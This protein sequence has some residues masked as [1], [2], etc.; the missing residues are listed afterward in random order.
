LR[1][2]SIFLVILIVISSITLV[3]SYTLHQIR[4]PVYIH[5]TL[6]EIERGDTGKTIAETL[7]K[8]NVISNKWLFH[9]VI[10]WKKLDTKL[11]AGHYLFSGHLTMMN[12]ISKLVSGEIL[13]VKIM[14]PEGISIYRIFNHL[15]KQGIG[16]YDRYVALAHDVTFVR[17]T[18]GM[19]IDSLEGFL[20][21]DTYIFG[22]SMSEETVIR[23]FVKNFFTRVFPP[24]IRMDNPNSFY[25]D[26]ILASIVER[27]AIFND[28]KPMIASVYL[29]RINKKMRLQADPTV[30]YHLEPDLSAHTTLVTYSMTREVTP[31]NTYVITGLPPQ[32]ICNPS[33]STIFAVQ[34]P[35]IS[36]YLFFFSNRRGRH[37]F[38][39]T[40]E[41][42]LNKQRERTS[43]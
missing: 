36:K 17:E 34:N 24:E 29:N 38:S 16:K 7:A 43:L 26:L 35:E 42:H 6:C 11:K 25:N 41:E 12:V 9:M 13:V 23:S 18:I 31:Y 32:P 19:Q 28:E 40:Y 8:N 15:S 14:I 22:H 20:Y 30:T 33:V 3:V 39:V 1:K 2:W 27:E 10:R 4:R 21:P 37:I 5:H